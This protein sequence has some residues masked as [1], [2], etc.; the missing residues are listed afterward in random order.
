MSIRNDPDFKAA[1]MALDSGRQRRVAAR[2]VGSA[3]ALC[4]DPRVT[5]AVSFAKRADISEAELSVIF[6]AA[7]QAA[8]ERYTH[9]GDEADWPNQ[10]GHFLA[11]AAM[12]CVAP[13]SPT[14]AWDVAMRVRV[15]RTCEA[16]ASGH[17]S[18]HSE[19]ENQYRLLE[20]F[21]AEQS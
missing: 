14:L 20:T 16:I 11:E 1:L 6:Q 3:Q 15:A 4:D 17:G 9:C 5:A 13:A 12:A 10:A 19:A 18:E 21:L 2:F 7:K 8:V